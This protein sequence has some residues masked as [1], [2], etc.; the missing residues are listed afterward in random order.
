MTALLDNTSRIATEMADQAVALFAAAWPRSLAAREVARLTEDGY[1][2]GSSC[3]LDF[4]VS[5]DDPTLVEKAI[6]QLA[7]AGFTPADRPDTDRGFLVVRTRGCL[8]PYELARLTSRVERAARQVGGYAELIG[9]ATPV[10]PNQETDL[11]TTDRE[12]PIEG[13]RPRHLMAS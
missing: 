7:R 3:E 5:F 9:P 8:S 10:F 13:Q 2:T 11:R 4:S 12:V 6:P 1:A